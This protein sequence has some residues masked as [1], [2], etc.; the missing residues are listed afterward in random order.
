MQQLFLSLGGERTSCDPCDLLEVDPV[1]RMKKPLTI[2]LCVKFLLLP[3]RHSTV[4]VQLMTVLFQW[5]LSWLVHKWKVVLCWYLS[6][7]AKLSCMAG[8]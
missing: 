7:V 8:E 5:L 4:L 2:F 3:T 1:M 6:V